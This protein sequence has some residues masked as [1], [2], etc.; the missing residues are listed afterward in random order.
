MASRSCAWAPLCSITRCTMAEWGCCRLPD[1][2]A[3]L[4]GSQALALISVCF[5]TPKLPPAGP[6]GRGSAANPQAASGGLEPADMGLPLRAWVSPFNLRHRGI[7]SV[8]RG[9]GYTPA[10][11]P[12]PPSVYVGKAGD[13]QQGPRMN[14]QLL[15]HCPFTVYKGPSWQPRELC[16]ADRVSP[17]D[18]ERGQCLGTQETGWVSDSGWSDCGVTTGRAVGTESP[19]KCSS[20]V[21]VGRAGGIHIPA[22][23]V[24]RPISFCS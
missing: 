4:C 14:L 23:L 16:R 11:P 12:L 2:R 7:L 1:S 22:A 3:P 21:T 6:A 8:M 5:K 24:P 18:G 19:D 20:S 13:R 17:L 15:D 9:V 10:L